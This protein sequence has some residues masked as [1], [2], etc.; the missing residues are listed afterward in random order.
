MSGTRFRHAPAADHDLVTVPTRTGLEAVDLLRLGEE[1]GPVL[2]DATGGTLGFLVPPGT[3]ERWELPGSACAPAPVPGA[4]RLPATGTGWLI[5]PEGAG[6][7][8][9]CP[10]RLREALR[11]ATR[12]LDALD[13]CRH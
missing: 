6:S 2:Y 1:L 13:R 12:T 5:A 3:A 11:R 4:D 10:D 9:T 7:G 8:A